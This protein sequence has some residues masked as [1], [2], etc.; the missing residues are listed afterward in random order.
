MPSLNA[1]YLLIGWWCGPYHDLLPKKQVG[2]SCSVKPHEVY[3]CELAFQGIVWEIVC[4]QS[5]QF[6]STALPLLVGWRRRQKLCA[7]RSDWTP[8]AANVPPQPFS[9]ASIISKDRLW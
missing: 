6:L 2:R 9:D 3:I 7:M 4:E 1:D 8:P 5:A